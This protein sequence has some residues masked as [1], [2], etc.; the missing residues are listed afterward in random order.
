MSFPKFKNPFFDSYPYDSACARPARDLDSVTSAMFASSRASYDLASPPLSPRAIIHAQ[1]H[2]PANFPS[3]VNPRQNSPAAAS[4]AAPQLVPCEGS[5]VARNERN[6]KIRKGTTF[7]GILSPSARKAAKEGKEV[8]RAIIVAR[9]PTPFEHS[10][11][12]ILTEESPRDG[13]PLQISAPDT[14]MPVLLP[15]TASAEKST[16]AITKTTAPM[17][18][19]DDDQPVSVK[20]Y[21]VHVVKRRPS[22]VFDMSFSFSAPS[23]RRACD[24]TPQISPRTSISSSRPDEGIPDKRQR[25]DSS[26]TH[27]FKWLGRLVSRSSVD[28]PRYDFDPEFHDSACDSDEGVSS[29]R[30]SPAYRWDTKNVDSFCSQSPES[31]TCDEVDLAKYPFVHT[32][33]EAHPGHPVNFSA[34]TRDDEIFGSV[35]APYHTYLSES[36]RRSSMPAP[37]VCSP[38]SKSHEDKN[39]KESRILGLTSNTAP[40]RKRACTLERTTRQTLPPAATS[41]NVSMASARTSSS[42]S[43][44]SS[45]RFLSHVRKS[46]EARAMKKGRMQSVFRDERETGWFDLGERP[47]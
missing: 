30:C 10:P 36:W 47:L 37:R 2:R 21:K 27:S 15:V 26:G 12:P 45:E 7:P 23:R 33:T 42:A 29:T 39:A 16:A 19:F 32:R 1:I 18:P 44:P 20:P 41:S 8:R 35:S 22:Q 14:P 5:H 24:R 25:I 11:P 13:S 6:N 38:K 40:N 34:P 28:H 43:D 31:N 9:R 4:A 3:I 17:D 46:L